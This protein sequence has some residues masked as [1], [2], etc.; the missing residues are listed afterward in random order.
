MAIYRSIH[1]SFWEDTKVCDDFTPEDKYFMLYCLT[2]SHTNIIGCYEISIRQIAN[3]MGYDDITIK[4]LLNRFEKE[5]KVILYDYK[6]KELF[7]KNWYKYNWNN[8]P[9]ID[10]PILEEI[11]KIKSIVFKKEL[12]GIYNKRDTVSIPYAYTMHTTVSVSD[13]VS[14]TISNTDIITD[15][16][17]YMNNVLNTNYKSTTESTKRFIR[18]RLNE[19]FTLEQFKK[20]IDK[21]Y[22][23]WG[24]DK[25]MAKFLRPETLF[26]TKFESYLNQ[27]EKKKTLKDISL[28]ELEE[29]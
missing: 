3:E 12:A 13:T 23:E 27:Q 6:T 19:G 1:I 22:N 15:I 18:A 28:K 2:N 14:D 10:I 17:N 20:V 8:S 25:T 4:K 9:K 29:L 5:H 24:Q 16:I 11:K 7:V 21:K 26:G